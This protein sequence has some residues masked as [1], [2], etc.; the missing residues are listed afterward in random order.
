MTHDEAFLNAIIEDPDS[1]VP[2]LLFADWLEERGDPRGEFIRLQIA[3]S[4]AEAGD[5]QLAEMQ[6]REEEMLTTH[7]RAWLGPLHSLAY[8]WTFKRGFPEEACL[9]A[10]HFLNCVETLF[11]LTP[12]RLVRLMKSGPWADGLAACPHL[13]RLRAL[14]MTDNQ[15]EDKGLQKLMASPYLGSIESLRLGNSWLTE[16][17]GLI[18]AEARHMRKLTTLSLSDNMLGDRGVKALAGASHLSKL[19]S[20]YLGNNQITDFGAQALAES[21]HF[22]RLKT[23]DLGNVAKNAMHGPNDI[24]S[25]GRELLLQRFS[26]AVCIL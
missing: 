13:R 19:T 6:R 7:R 15:I 8:S 24:K 21:P 18:L 25:K 4:R 22:S 9:P 11:R 16:K 23:L 5:E 20:L 2:R 3:I 17:S 14:H 1:N 10:E 12:L 26:G